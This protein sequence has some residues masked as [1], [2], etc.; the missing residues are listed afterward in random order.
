MKH[1]VLLKSCFGFTFKAARWSY[2]E[3][4]YF[5]VLM[6]YCPKF[7]V[8]AF[9]MIR[10][11]NGTRY[12]ALF[13]SEKYAIFN[14]IGSLVS[15]KIHILDVGSHNYGNIEIDSDD[16]LTLEETLN[17]YNAFIL[18]KLVFNKNKYQHYCNLLLEKCLH[19]LASK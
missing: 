6:T 8:K 17:L 3:F 5:F 18:I 19:Q 14:R 9:R 12:L 7:G 1:T 11:Y 15:L 4:F 13:G 2:S 16:Y 10:D